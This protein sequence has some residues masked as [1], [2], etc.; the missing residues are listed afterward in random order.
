M[1][2]VIYRDI[3]CTALQALAANEVCHADIHEGNICIRADKGGNLKATLIDLES[4]VPYGS[5][6]DRTPIK[7]RHENVKQSRGGLDTAAVGA[8]LEGLW[9]NGSFGKLEEKVLKW[10]T[11]YYEEHGTET[12]PSFLGEIRAQVGQR[13]NGPPASTTRLMET[14]IRFS[15]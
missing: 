14:N 5:D 13:Y 4:A 1:P 2:K 15:L 6:L 3:W 10:T 7:F 9:E 8:I 12:H 11:Y